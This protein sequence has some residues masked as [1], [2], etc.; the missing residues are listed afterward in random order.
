VHYVNRAPLARSRLTLRT[1]AV[2]F[3]NAAVRSAAVLTKCT[4]GDPV[5]ASR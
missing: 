1:Y 4:P 5:G 3:V 2:L